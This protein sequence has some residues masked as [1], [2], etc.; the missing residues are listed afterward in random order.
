[1][2]ARIKEAENVQIIAELKHKIAE[3][4]IQVLF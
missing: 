2:M 3:I 4:E 1:M